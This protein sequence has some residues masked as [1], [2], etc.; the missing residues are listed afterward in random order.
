MV[1]VA[2]QD[3]LLDATHE[4]L[5]TLHPN[6]SFR[7]VR[8]TPAPTATFEYCGVRVKR[9]LRRVPVSPCCNRS[10]FAALAA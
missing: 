3:Q 8:I 1:L 5:S 9:A 7:K 2:L 4:E 10:K 6:V